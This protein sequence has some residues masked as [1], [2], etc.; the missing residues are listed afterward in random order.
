MQ[1]AV[2]GSQPPP[3]T[4]EGVPA[5]IARLL[6][7]DAVQKIAHD[8]KTARRALRR[9]GA[10][11]GGLAMDTMIASYLV[12]ASRRYHALEDLAA[13]R[14]HLEVPLLP[15]ADRKDPFR[16]PTL[17]ERVARAGAGA[18]AAAR[19]G[20]QFGVELERLGLERLYR[21]VELP[22]VAVSTPGIA[23]SPA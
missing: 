17:D 4:T 3:K 20:E 6:E 11:L 1:P 19:L 23:R 5:A 7:D 9:S 21:D 2:A 14:L 22:L 15:V 12:N 8:A 13:E 16:T 18:V 10:D